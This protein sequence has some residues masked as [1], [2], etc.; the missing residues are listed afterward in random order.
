MSENYCKNPLIICGVPN[1]GRTVRA[2]KLCKTHYE[3]KRLGQ[4][5]AS[6]KYKRPDGTPPRIVCDE[7]QCPRLDLIGPCHIFRYGK[8]DDGYGQVRHNGG[9]R[10]VHIYVWELENG[11]VPDG[12]EID[13]Q[14]MVRGCCNIDH[15]RCVTHQVNSTENSTSLAAKNASKTHCDQGHLFDDNNTYYG[16]KGDRVCRVCRRRHDK[17]R[18]YRDKAR[19]AVSS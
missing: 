8:N 4:P 3:N 17:N 9:V 19:I 15:L 16:T 1:C 2:A 6:I 18:Y 5:F 12:F 11:P 13:H 14:C 7:A 10:K